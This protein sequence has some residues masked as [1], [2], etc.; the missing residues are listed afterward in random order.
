MA[1]IF[2]LRKVAGE[3]CIMLTSG[4]VALCISDRPS[5]MDINDD[6]LILLTSSFSFVAK[7]TNPAKVRALH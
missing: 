2:E 5:T 3:V 4:I 6:A 1:A 7:T